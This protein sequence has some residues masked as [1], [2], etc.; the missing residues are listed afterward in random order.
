MTPEERLIVAL[1][2]PSLADALSVADE[3]KGVAGCFT[4]GL[5]RLMAEGMPKVAREFSARSLS[6]FADVKFADI[7]NTVGRATSVL[8]RWGVK[9]FDVH[10]CC[11]RESVEQAVLHKKNSKLLVVTVLT[12]LNDEHARSIFGGG[13][14]AKVIE[15]AK[16]ARDAG[17]D[18]IIC[19]PDELALLA[20]ERCVSSLLKITPG[21]RP[22]WAAANDQKRTATPEEAI[23]RGADCIVVGRPILQPPAGMKP[24]EAAKK[25]LREIERGLK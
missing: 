3:L 21:V 8:A 7:P 1:D 18:G 24:V 19:S 16:M 20:S 15:F 14:G 12:S 2:V 6:L 23:S 4:V 17:A 10:A 11:G 5:E 22:A 25:V 13:A 9:Y